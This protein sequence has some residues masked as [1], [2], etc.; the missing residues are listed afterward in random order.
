M[1]DALGS[2]QADSHP[3]SDDHRPLGTRPTSRR[4]WPVGVLAL[5]A[6]VVL[7]SVALLVLLMR[8]DA[9]Y[10]ADSAEAALQRYVEAWEAGDVE[11]A[12]GALSSRAQERRSLSAFKDAWS[13]TEGS[14][15]RAWID[16]RRDAGDRVILGLTVELSHGGLL[17]PDRERYRPRVTLDPRG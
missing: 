2:P 6:L 3:M 13:R 17:R 9:E 5:L 1:S 14:A 16:E 11:T 7:A 12:Y 4:A 10:G 8:Q 15:V